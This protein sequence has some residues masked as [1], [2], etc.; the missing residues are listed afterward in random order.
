MLAIAFFGVFAISPTLST[1]A[2]L[3]KQLADNRSADQMLQTTITNLS[4]LE[5]K[6]IDI[7]N[8]LPAVFAAVPQNPEVPLLVGQLYAIAQSNNLTVTRITTDPIS[9]APVAQAADS[10]GKKTTVGFS[11][12]VLGN[13][14]DMLSCLQQMASF[15]RIITIDSLA[16]TTDTLTGD[17]G[18]AD[19]LSMTVKGKAYFKQ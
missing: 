13:R 8:D 2:N 9:L 12:T 3:Q 11:L 10:G 15:E 16:I 14:D 1:I 4:T 7:Q 17:T 19:Q 6:Y 5:Q 18:S